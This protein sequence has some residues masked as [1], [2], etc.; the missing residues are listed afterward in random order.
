MMDIDIIDAEDV[1][2]DEDEVFG[3]TAHN[4]EA[5]IGASASKVHSTAMNHFNK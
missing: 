1:L 3:F 5:N 2:S 4:M